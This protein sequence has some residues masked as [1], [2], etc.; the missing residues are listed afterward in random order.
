[1]GAVIS[2]TLLFLAAQQLI[3]DTTVPCRSSVDLCNTT[4]PC[5]SAVDLCNTTVPCRSA[6][7]L[8][9]TTVPCRS[10]VISV[11]LLF[12]AAQQ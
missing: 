1:M 5:R 12:L 8:Y 7:D 9:N 3:S 6:V 2:V 11:T 4:V 10:A